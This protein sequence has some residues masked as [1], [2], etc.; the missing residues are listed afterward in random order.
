M[1]F[2][3]TVQRSVLAFIANT[4]LE[5]AFRPVLGGRGAILMLH[6][7]KP[8]PGYDF[9]PNAHLEITPQFLDELLG[10]MSDWGYE[11]VHLHDIPKALADGESRKR[12]AAITMDDGYKDN[13]EIAAPIFQKHKAPYTVF[14]VPGFFDGFAL[15]WWIISEEV[16]RENASISYRD[17]K[18][19]VQELA[20]GS[21]AEKQQAYKVLGDLYLT[22]D[23][24]RV[25]DALKE[26]C[27]LNAIDPFAICQQAFLSWEDVKRM[28][29]DPLCSIGG[30]TE[31]HPSL[32]RLSDQSVRKE[33]AA[34][35]E[36]I[37]KHVGEKPRVFAYP[38]GFKS[39]AGSR[40]FEIAKELGLDCAVTTRPGLIYDRHKDYLTA[41]PRLSVNGLFQEPR[42]LK[43]LLSGLPF[44]LA[45]AGK[46]VDVD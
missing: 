27:E 44:F 36:Q 2:R 17:A 4:G 43:A 45:N 1:D 6:R 20:T 22:M 23:Q 31:L 9:Q 7:V 26:L 28:I 21:M 33:M 30:H 42:Y 10:L 40:E 16:I 41:L 35:L 38:F 34:G 25:F 14:L 8:A 15:P 46:R 5:I 11:W 19:S 39:T 32:A 13:L 12:F 29:A 18:G 24:D 3:R 37:A